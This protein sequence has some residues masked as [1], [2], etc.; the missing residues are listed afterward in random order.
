MRNS[1]KLRRLIE[2]KKNTMLISRLGREVIH[3]NIP[4]KCDKKLCEEQ[5]GE[6]I[7]CDSFLKHTFYCRK[8]KVQKERMK[9]KE[10]ANAC[11]ELLDFEGLIMS[12]QS[13]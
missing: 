2:Q 9:V 3:R 13:L 10:E 5:C 11:C 12:V 1:E 8:I 4:S 7:S 6:E